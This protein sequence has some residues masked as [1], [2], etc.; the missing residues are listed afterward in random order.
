MKSVRKSMIPLLVALLVGCG[1]GPVRK[2]HPSTASIQQL[3]VEP[4][5]R[6]RLSLR[7]QNFSN[8]PMHYSRIDAN[9]QIDGGDAGRIQA[10]PDIDIVANG[11][12]V[13]ELRMP[14]EIVLPIGRDFLYRLQGTIE[15]SSPKA[16]YKFERSSRLSPVPGVAD[17]WR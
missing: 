13:F 8:V 3:A 14:A 2:L 5:G 1:G 9:L 6:W 17:T 4:D 10:D 12:D 16:R 15:T 7:L 11:G